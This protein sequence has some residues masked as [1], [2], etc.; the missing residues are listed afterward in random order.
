MLV[1]L[2]M[3]RSGTSLLQSLLSLDPSTRTTRTWEMMTTFP[4]PKNKEETFSCKRCVDKEKSFDQIDLFCKHWRKNFNKVH[5]FAANGAEEDTMVL[6]QVFS[7]WYH[8]YFMKDLDDQL[9]H[10]LRERNDVIVRFLHLFLRVLEHGYS[11]ESHWVLKNPDSCQYIPEF[12]SEFPKANFVMTHRN[13]CSIVPSWAN[14][15]LQ[16][17][18][19]RLHNDCSSFFP[20]VSDLLYKM[21]PIVFF[22]LFHYH[23]LNLTSNE[24]QVL[25]LYVRG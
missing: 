3:H 7:V 8:A 14:M 23:W 21:H 25:F 10:L 17:L 13:P 5:Y 2:G 19:V 20:Q 4:P 9:H 6:F 11:P 15:M 18:H 22:C 16:C 24:N 1:I 12:V